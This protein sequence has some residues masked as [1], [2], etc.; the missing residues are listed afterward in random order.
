MA[1]HRLPPPLKHGAYSGLGLLPGEDAAAF[2]KMHVELVAEH[3]PVGLLEQ[4]I[5]ETM[6]RL[7]WRK[8][9]LITYRLAQ[10]AAKR[11]AEITTERYGA[12]L[13]PDGA[14]A[15]AADAMRQVERR[16]AQRELGPAWPLVEL[17]EVAT[18]DYLLHELSL[19]DRLDGMIDLP[20]TLAV[21][22][23][24]QVAFNRVGA[25]NS[26]YPITTA[27]RIPLLG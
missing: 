14:E 26:C 13:D 2:D 21:R 10:Q 25:S 6:A 11:W 12:A 23:R 27:K 15:G 19:A 16:R 4:K 18:I 20:Q 17:N 5:V 3:H 24:S 9:H 8:D 22:S 7:I 1:H